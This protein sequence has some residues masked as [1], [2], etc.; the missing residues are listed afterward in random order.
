MDAW[1]CNLQDKTSVYMAKRLMFTNHRFTIGGLGDALAV[2][3]NRHY[4]N[5]VL[6]RVSK[7]LGKGYFTLGKEH[8]ANI[9]SGKGSLSSTF[10]G[11]S[12]KTL[13]SIKK[14]SAKKNTRQIKNEKIKK[15]SKTFF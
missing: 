7:T 10:F 13:P 4:R 6:C 12:A 1:W 11:H 9:S 5:R 15:N 2:V 14:H 8:S 3:V